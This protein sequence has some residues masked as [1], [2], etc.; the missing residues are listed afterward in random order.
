M[1]LLG[2]DHNALTVDVDRTAD[3]PLLV[4]V[5]DLDMFTEHV[6]SRALVGINS[7]CALNMSG[8]PFIDSCGLRLLVQHA[9]R[10]A[11]EGWTLS[12]R[13]PSEQVLQLLY[14]TGLGGWIETLG[15]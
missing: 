11:G 14:I 10:L 3:T 6:L 15:K 9:R 13:E 5:G 4:V 12:I 1:G 8:V 2:E 7:S